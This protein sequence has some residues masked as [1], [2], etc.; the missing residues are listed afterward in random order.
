MEFSA[1]RHTICM[2]APLFHVFGTIVSI[3][4]AVNHASTI[5]LPTDGY[6]PDKTL[7]ALK[8]EKYITVISIEYFCMLKI[9][10]YGDLWYSYDVLRP[11]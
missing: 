1:K 3:M 2:Q 7:D 9:Q 11:H 5:V 10:V 6:Q 4:T 8:N